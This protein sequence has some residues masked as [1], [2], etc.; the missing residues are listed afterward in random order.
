MSDMAGS[1]GSRGKGSTGRGTGLPI[2][3]SGL[4]LLCDFGKFQVEK[5]RQTLAEVMTCAS[6]ESYNA[7]F[8]AA[9]AVSVILEEL[10]I[11][12]IWS[13][14]KRFYAKKDWEE[15]IPTREHADLRSML[16]VGNATL[17][18]E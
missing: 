7:G 15:C 18:T 5:D 12:V 14:K 11:R 8:G 6:Q 13:I 9:M 4:F 3:F 17:C 16:I 2:P 10:M 1:S